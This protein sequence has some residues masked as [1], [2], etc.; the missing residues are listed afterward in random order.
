MSTSR[1]L[2]GR[3]QFLVASSACA[4]ATATLGPK[5]FANTGA[6]PRRLA[7]GFARFGETAA[8]I[9]AADLRA[10][11]GAFI[12]RGARI[13]VSG[14][15]GASVN[16]IDRRAVELLAHYSYMDGN[17]RKV[18]PYR[19]WGCSRATGCQ[20]NSVKFTIPVDATQKIV[21]SVETERGLP[22][23]AASRREALS[24][25]TPEAVALPVTLTLQD[26]PDTKLV[27]GFYVIV[28]LFDNDREPRWSR[29]ELKQI[30]SRWALADR[31]GNTAPFEHFVLSID[32][33]SAQ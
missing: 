17:E 5:L 4:M 20:G 33:A 22:R 10:G 24:G 30:D 9:A 6:P 25:A 16:P 21:F 7:V 13:S 15:S 12:S 31:D 1:L 28:P 23:P 19:A 29:Y 26:G 32:Y 8:V 18:A 14:A 27:R 11:D 2:I 3:R